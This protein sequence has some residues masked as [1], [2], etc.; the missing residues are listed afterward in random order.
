MGR[1]GDRGMNVWR[2]EG[3][4]DAG[5]RSGGAQGTVWCEG[6]GTQQHGDGE[7]QRT[8]VGR[9]RGR[10]IGGWGGSGHR[11]RGDAEDWGTRLLG[12]WAA[13]PG[14]RGRSGGAKA[15]GMWTWGT[16]VAIRVCRDGA[17]GSHRL[18][19]GEQW[20]H[21]EQRTQG[22]EG[23]SE[24][25]QWGHSKQSEGGEQ[26]QDALEGAGGCATQLFH[27]RFGP[28]RWGLGRS[29]RCAAGGS[30]VWVGDELC[31]TWFPFL[32]GPL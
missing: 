17:N 4:G 20:G 7:V 31:P 23:Q 29:S 26:L 13:Q 6:H 16:G 21:R 2:C 11:D 25:G 22:Q 9:G 28:K 24:G 32:P 18:R 8:G 30:G 5:Q 19:V 1:R 27:F 10:G 3:R 12:G 15:W 14:G